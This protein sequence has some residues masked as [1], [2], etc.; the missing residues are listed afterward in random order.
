MGA[1]SALVEASI[2]DASHKASQALASVIAVLPLVGV[3]GFRAL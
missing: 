2:S 1:V 3:C